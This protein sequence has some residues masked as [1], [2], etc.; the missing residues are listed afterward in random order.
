MIPSSPYWEKSCFSGFSP[1][2]MQRWRAVEKWPQATAISAEMQPHHSKK[3]IN[4]DKHNDAQHLFKKRRG[5]R[6][7][8]LLCKHHIQEFLYVNNVNIL[9]FLWNKN[10]DRLMTRSP[11]RPSWCSQ[12]A[13]SCDLAWFGRSRPRP[14][15][16]VIREHPASRCRLYVALCAPY[17]LLSS[18]P[19]QLDSA[20]WKCFSL[21]SVFL[22]AGH[23]NHI[24]FRL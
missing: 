24:F 10:R 5:H 14:D 3:H 17:G 19:P 8:T 1:C 4:P 18:S 6:F 2:S 12:L 15:E 11:Q 7:L 16:T 23:K 21:L 20:G 9:V 13:K 22:E